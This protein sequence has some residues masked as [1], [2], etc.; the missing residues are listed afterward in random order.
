VDQFN[1]KYRLKEE[2]ALFN[3]FDVTAPEGYFSLNDKIG[4][5]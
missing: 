3:W 5:K 2:G 1:V 4:D